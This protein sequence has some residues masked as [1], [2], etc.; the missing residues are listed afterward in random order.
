[1]CNNVKEFQ[2]TKVIIYKLFAILQIANFAN[3]R[4]RHFKTLH[5]HDISIAEHHT[6]SIWED[7]DELAY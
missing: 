5:N 4:C 7:L 3:F 6:T 1:M 2:T